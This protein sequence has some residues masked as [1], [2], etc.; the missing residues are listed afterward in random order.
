MVTTGYNSH[1]AGQSCCRATRSHQIEFTWHTL[2]AACGGPLSQVQRT[3]GRSIRPPAIATHAYIS[4]MIL[5]PDG[6]SRIAS[7]FPD[8]QNWS[9]NQAFGCITPPFA[10][11]PEITLV[12]PDRGSRAE[13]EVESVTAD[14]FTAVI[15]TSDQAGRWIGR[16]RGVP[17]G[18]EVV[19][20]V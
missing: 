5:P 6:N 17:L 16:A 13:P 7:E 12:G 14:K 2:W 18:Q 8:L 15:R 19:T 4:V 9:A 3:A 20:S 10:Y 11:P 1:D